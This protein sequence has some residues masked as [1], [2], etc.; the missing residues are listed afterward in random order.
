M[1]KHWNEIGHLCVE[2][3]GGPLVTSLCMIL[4][5]GGKL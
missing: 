5:L 1:M 2:F 4:K 3:K